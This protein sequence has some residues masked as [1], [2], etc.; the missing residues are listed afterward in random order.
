MYRQVTVNVIQLSQTA[1]L[2]LLPSLFGCFGCGGITAFS[3]LMYTITHY[4]LSATTEC[5]RVCLFTMV[6]FGLVP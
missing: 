3:C 2:Y 4:V 1:R 5:H 6:K